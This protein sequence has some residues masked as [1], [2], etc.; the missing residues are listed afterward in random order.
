MEA[1]ERVRLFQR[2]PPEE[3]YDLAADPFEINNLA[4]E[5]SLQ[6]LKADLRKRLRKWMNEQND[7]LAD[8]V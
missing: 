8:L 2:R 5:P 3:L 7:P 6:E 4:E 1:A